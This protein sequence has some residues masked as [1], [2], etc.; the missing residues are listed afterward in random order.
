M[1]VWDMKRGQIAMLEMMMHACLPGG[2]ASRSHGGEEYEMSKNDKVQLVE[3]WTHTHRGKCAST[4]ALCMEG[5]RRAGGIDV[6]EDSLPPKRQSPACG[7]PWQK[8]RDEAREQHVQHA[9]VVLSLFFCQ[10]FL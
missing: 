9:C 5:R 4:S 7:R 10:I 6:E 8:M 1:S 2:E 3:G